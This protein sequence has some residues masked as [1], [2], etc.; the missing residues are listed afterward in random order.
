[1]K[2]SDTRERRRERARQKRL[3]DKLGK[4]EARYLDIWKALTRENSETLSKAQRLAIDAYLADRERAERESRQRAPYGQSRATWTGFRAGEPWIQRMALQL[5][6]ELANARENGGDI[7][8]YWDTMALMWAFGRAARRYGKRRRLKL[9][10]GS[11]K[12]FEIW[13]TPAWGREAS[14]GRPLAG[15]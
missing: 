9:R 5:E 7:L 1:L 3:R 8:D 11:T 4:E 14:T 2:P 15:G 10:D 13:P 12:V 6:L